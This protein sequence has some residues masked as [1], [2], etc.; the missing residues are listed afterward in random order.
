MAAV[1][2]AGVPTAVGYQWRYLDTLDHVQALLGEA[3]PRL[4]LGRWFTSTPR[5]PWWRRQALS[6]G[7]L[8]EQA[9]HLVDL[10]RLLLGEVTSVYAAGGRT[11]RPSFPDADV[12]DV[13]SVVMRLASGAV[14]TITATCLLHWHDRI[15][16]ELVGEGLALELAEGE[17]T[18]RRADGTERR[19][20]GVDP[21][22]REERDFLDAVRGGP[23]RIRVPYGEALATHR[24]VVA[25]ARSAR[26]AIPISLPLD[27][28]SRVDR[29]RVGVLHA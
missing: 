18:I 19:S 17:L 7:Q 21:F 20:A 24:V 3:P 2:E 15:A 23:S 13:S 8:V 1:T 6:G 4:A 5:A 27:G 12:D 29:D 25:A 16:L 10:V 11:V 14:A 28:A 26:E 22:V 9:T